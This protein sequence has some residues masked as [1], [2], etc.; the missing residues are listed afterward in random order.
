[1][2]MSRKVNYPAILLSVA[3]TVTLLSGCAGS[4]QPVS[5]QE[6][7]AAETA[8]ATKE[9]VHDPVTLKFYN[10]NP[11][12]MPEDQF[13]TYLEAPVK[14][15]Y[16]YISFEFIQGSTG[17]TKPN[18]ISHLVAAGTVPD[19]I[20]SGASNLFEFVEL[21]LTEDIMPLIKKHNFDLDRMDDQSVAFLRKFSP[22]DNLFALPFKYGSIVV[23][24][25]KDIFDKFGAPYPKD[26]MTWDEIN[27]LTKRVTRTVDGVKYKGFSGVFSTMFN[28]NQLGMSFVDPKTLRASVNSEAGRKILEP[29]IKLYSIPGNEFD[30]K[31]ANDNNVF[32]KDKNLAMYEN[33]N[34]IYLFDENIRKTL[35]WDLVTVPLFDRNQKTGSG[36]FPQNIVITKTS[37]NKDAAFLTVDTLLS[38]EVQGQRASILGAEPILKKQ[39][40]RDQFMKEVDY[41]VGKNVGAFFKANPAPPRNLTKFDNQANTDFTTA[42]EDV[43]LKKSDLNTALRKAEDKINKRIDEDKAK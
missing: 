26:F 29:L 27:E 38:D 18:T 41:A 14:K 43:L 30:R 39:S 7:T 10:L 34:I 9:V 36:P 3:L 42:M 12:V 15:K 5:K 1:M 17:S 21:G 4:G 8:S 40:V 28:Y 25:N 23:Y 37:K 19:I 2:M 16:P 31:K 6:A 35:N 13:K 32:M 20:V 33:S 22:D 11:V 24:Y